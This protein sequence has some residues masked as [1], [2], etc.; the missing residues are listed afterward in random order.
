VEDNSEQGFDEDDVYTMFTLP[1]TKVDP[2][3]IAVVIDSILLLM[4]LDAGTLLPLPVSLY[5]SHCSHAYPCSLLQ[6]SSGPIQVKQLG[7]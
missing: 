3:Q 6:Q 1:P 2:I 7:C 4:E 5:T